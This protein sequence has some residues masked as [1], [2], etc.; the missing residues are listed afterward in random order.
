MNPNEHQRVVDLLACAYRNIELDLLSIY[1]HAGPG[2]DAEAAVIRSLE[3]SLGLMC[4]AIALADKLGDENTARA[5]A[6]RAAKVRDAIEDHRE[7]LAAW[8]EVPILIA[9]DEADC[10][11][12]H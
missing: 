8:L 11:T 4:E 7:Q 10:S 2:A 3:F 5:T 9:Q 1:R 6:A 12:K